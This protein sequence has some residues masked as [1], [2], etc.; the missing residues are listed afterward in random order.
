MKKRDRILVNEKF[1]DLVSF[2]ELGYEVVDSD[3]FGTFLT[4][5]N[6]DIL[7]RI[8]YEL[9]DSYGTELNISSIHYSFIAPQVNQ[10]LMSLY[11][12]PSL[13]GL[14]IGL[15]SIIEHTISYKS[16][17]EE[18]ENFWKPITLIKIEEDGFFYEERLIEASELFIKYMDQ[19]MN[20]FFESITSLQEINNK[21]VDGFPEDKW[22]DFFH[23]ETRFKVT[24]I[25]KLCNNPRYET[26]SQTSKE[27][28]Y[29]LFYN[30][31]VAEYEGYY[32]IYCVLLDYLEEG[33]FNS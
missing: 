31:G 9:H 29:S 7:N 27:M 21:I 15:S 3:S 19:Y 16:T 5:P 30:K 22:R 4:K 26:F 2:K 33:T 25:M 24:V 23:G 14:K 6:G 32:K 1:K 13:S 11:S 12:V 18:F 17:I 20:P 28:M 10:V 8:L